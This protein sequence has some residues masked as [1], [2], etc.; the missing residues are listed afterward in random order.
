[1]VTIATSPGMTINLWL[2]RSIQP[3]FYSSFQGPKKTDDVTRRLTDTSKYTGAHKE[4]FDEGGKGKG[5]GGRVEE[6]SNSG[7]VGGYKNE[8][9]YKK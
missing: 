7:Y 9:T 1:M 8:G 4:R 2:Q 6:V 3:S 5:K